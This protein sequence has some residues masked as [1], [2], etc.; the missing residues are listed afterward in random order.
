MTDGVLNVD[1]V[2][3]IFVLASKHTHKLF[4]P[5]DNNILVFGLFLS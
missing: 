5:Q 2:T 1:A 3:L 4:I